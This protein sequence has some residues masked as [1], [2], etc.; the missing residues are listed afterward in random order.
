MTSSTNINDVLNFVQDKSFEQ[1]KI[2]AVENGIIV[3]EKQSE[4]LQNL[5]LLTVDKEIEKTTQLTQLQRQC[6]GIIFEKNTNKVIAMC[7]NKLYDIDLPDQIE[8]MLVEQNKG[9]ILQNEALNSRIE[10]CEDGTIIRLYHYNNKWYTAT[11]RC[12]NA[13]DSWWSSNKTFDEMF[14]SIFDISNLSLLN[15]SCTYIFVLLHVDNRI[16]VKHFRNSL[17]YI[18][19]INNETTE[20]DY[21]NIF[22]NT[23]AFQNKLIRRPK[24]IPYINIYEIQNYFY[25]TKRGIIIKFYNTQ[26]QTWSVYKYDFIQYRTVKDVRGNVPHIRM[27][28]LELLTDSDKLLMLEK[29]YPESQLMFEIIKNSL[30]KLTRYIHKMYVDSHIKHIIQITEEDMYYRTLRQL[31]AQY[32][33]TN[34]PITYEDVHQKLVSLDKNVLKK[35]LGWVN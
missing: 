13:T 2:D 31:H 27:R 1:I 10:Y 32:K 14:W 12:M 18:Q 35:F 24:M 20:E 26:S 6:N 3:K 7:Q 22:F 28:Y 8:N 9:N 16:V 19:S 34:K 25:P 21:K 30:F 23:E 33:I 4:E 17:V 11:T 5:Y 29:F 15:T